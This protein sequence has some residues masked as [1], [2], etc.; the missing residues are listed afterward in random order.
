MAPQDTQ[1]CDI[2]IEGLPV[3]LVL[4]IAE[5]CDSF[6]D[7]ASLART[8][9]WFYKILNPILYKL[10]VQSGNPCSLFWACQYGSLETLQLVHKAGAS[11]TQ[12][13]TSKKA[14]R[15]LP[16]NPYR[17][18]P[19]FYQKV[20]LRLTDLQGDGA[21]AEETNVGCDE[22]PY[23]DDGDIDWGMIIDNDQQYEEP[24]EPVEENMW[25]S[26]ENG[27]EPETDQSWSE[28]DHLW[29]VD[30]DEAGQSLLKTA[31]QNSRYTWRN[32]FLKRLSQYPEHDPEIHGENPVYSS[33]DNRR[34]PLYWWHPIDLA[35]RFGHKEII[36]YLVENGVSLVSDAQSRGLCRE[37]ELSFEPSFEGC[38]HGASPF[39]RPRGGEDWRY[40]VHHIFEL[41][42]CSRNWQMGN[43]L[44]E[45]TSTSKPWKP[46]VPYP[47]PGVSDEGSLNWGIWR[48]LEARHA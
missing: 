33:G 46:P 32:D 27:T 35:V 30:T 13:W 22:Q 25:D 21:E 20:A 10:D 5:S 41:I 34:F 24:E 18:S 42:L 15:D 16:P 43:F 48:A 31:S 23:P 17:H 14:L 11:L 44:G 28:D 8:S 38:D 45:I 26:E 29:P 47:V 19:K 37:K 3:E 9:K 1:E 12:A 40:F 2:P 36:R 4:E 6:S 7:L 39:M